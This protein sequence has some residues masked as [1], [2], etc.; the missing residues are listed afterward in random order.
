MTC[1]T[2][3]FS[4]S[5]CVIVLTGCGASF[6]ERRRRVRGPVAEVGLIDPGGGHVRYALRGPGWLVRARRRKA[7]KKMAE[8]CEGKELVR[9]EGEYS[10]EDV[11]TPFHAADL[12][13]KKLLGTGHYQVE[14]YRHILF[15][16][17]P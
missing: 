2:Q 9:V 6:V 11:L 5:L 13:E 10:R 7:F 14:E 12:D 4:L 3:V 1:Q 16:C 15:R 8:Y 17:E